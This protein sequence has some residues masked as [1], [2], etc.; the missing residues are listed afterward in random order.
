M[1][2]LTFDVLRAYERRIFAWNF[3]MQTINGWKCSK[4]DRILK[5]CE[6]FRRRSIIMNSYIY[7][8]DKYE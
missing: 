4:Y 6:A 7:I 8:C 2:W 1:Y 5:L 3:K